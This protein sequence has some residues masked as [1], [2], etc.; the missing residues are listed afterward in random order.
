VS[1]IVALI[2]CCKTKLDRRAPA[3]ELYTGRLFRLSL[4]YADAVLGTGHVGILSAKHGLVSPS[5]ELD[6]YEQELPRAY[7]P[8]D[9]WGRWVGPQI[10]SAFGSF[11][12][13]TSVVF[14]AGEAYGICRRHVPGRAG[15]WLEPLRGMQ[16]G[17]RL[18]WLKRQLEGV[19]R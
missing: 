19:R 1:R 10:A 12:E 16:I 2:G 13:G 18:S 3:R 6:P 14:L 5:L 11:D 8:L 9:A 17:E 7:E 4:E 15:S